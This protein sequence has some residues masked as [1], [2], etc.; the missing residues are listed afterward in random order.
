MEFSKQEMEL[1]HPF[2]LSG[3]KNFFRNMIFIWSKDSMT[4]FKKWNW[5]LQT[6]NGIISPIST[7]RIKKIL[8]KKGNRN[9]INRKE[10]YYTH[11]SSMDQKTSCAFDQRI[12]KQVFQTVNRICK[13]EVEFANRKWIFFP[14]SAPRIKRLL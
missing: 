11:F 2:L 7:F 6:G 9:P 4:S 13:Q 14:I 12:P 8:L 10:H 1:F 5:I 3:S